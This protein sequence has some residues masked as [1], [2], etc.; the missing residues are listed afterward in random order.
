MCGSHLSISLN[1]FALRRATQCELGK[2]Q[3]S[4]LSMSFVAC[5]LARSGGDS[6]RPMIELQRFEASRLRFE[7]LAESRLPRMTSL[8]L[9]PLLNLLYSPGS[10]GCSPVALAKRF[11]IS[12]KETTPFRRPDIYAPG[13]AEAETT[14]ADD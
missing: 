7:L 14:G 6:N 1:P 8:E 5:R 4:I 11:R 3:I 12:V 10:V 13:I 2:E 9:E